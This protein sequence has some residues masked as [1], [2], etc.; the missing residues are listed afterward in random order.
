MVRNTE[1]Y[2]VGEQPCDTFKPTRNEY[3]G[4]NVEHQC[5]NCEGFRVFCRNCSRDHH[6][7]GW[8]PCNRDTMI[9]EQGT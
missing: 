3:Y 9:R 2:E 5:P 6:A 8:G 1:N 7:G 4:H